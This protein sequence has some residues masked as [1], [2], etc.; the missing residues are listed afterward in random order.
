MTTL[1]GRLIGIEEP[2][3]N[4]HAWPHAFQQYW[5]GE[6][7]LKEMLDEYALTPFTEAVTSLNI[8]TDRFTLPFGH[9]WAEDEGVYFTTTGTFP[10]GLAG[11]TI[12]YILNPNSGT[13]T[14][15][16]S[17]TKV[18][19]AVNMTAQGTG[20]LSI[21]LIDEDVIHWDDTR[22]LV[23]HADA[24]LQKDRRFMWDQGAEG[25]VLLGEDDFPG[26]ITV[27]SLKSK[28]TGLANRLKE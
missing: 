6:I 25:I 3:I 20:T 15:A 13:G 1:Y 4:A 23:V 9:D 11:D 12:Y 26:Y 2:K 10:T 18:G 27:A 7:P 5:G 19:S 8:V 16:V 24:D 17:A 21:N 22:K 28:L 14:S